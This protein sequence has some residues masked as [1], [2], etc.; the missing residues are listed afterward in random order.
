MWNK[1]PAFFL[2]AMECEGDLNTKRGKMN[3][4]IKLLCAADDPNDPEEQASAFEEAGLDIED[5]SQEEIDYIVS[6]VETRLN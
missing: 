2:Y 4:V 1:D 6:E 5:L 3:K